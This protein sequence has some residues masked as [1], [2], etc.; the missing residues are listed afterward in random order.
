M[1]THGEKR[2]LPVGNFAAASTEKPIAIDSSSDTARGE[3]PSHHESECGDGRDGRVR[4]AL[5]RVA[6][7]CSHVARHEAPRCHQCR[8]RPRPRASLRIR[9]N[10]Q[11]GASSTHPNGM[12]V[13]PSAL[14]SIHRVSAQAPAAR[15]TCGPAFPRREV[16]WPKSALPCSSPRAGLRRFRLAVRSTLGCDTP[17]DAESAGRGQPLEA[18]GGGSRLTRLRHHHD[19]LRQLAAV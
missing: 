14:L 3:P 18:C 8:S 16:C 7:R 6:E 15:R 5:R 19:C 12:A 11:L 1:V 4:L 17:A 2:S 9:P 10:S 13:E